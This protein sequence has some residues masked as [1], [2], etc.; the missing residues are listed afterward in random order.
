M[1]FVFNHVDDAV[2]G[3]CLPQFSR[4]LLLVFLAAAA[5][6]FTQCLLFA[7]RPCEHSKHAYPVSTGI[8]EQGV[9]IESL[10]MSRGFTTYESNVLFALR[11][12]IDH[13]VVGG[14]WVEL[15]AGMHT[16][17]GPASSNKL[18]HC[19]ME[20]HIHCNKL[21]SHKPEGMLECPIEKAVHVDATH[22]FFCRIH[23]VHC[24]HGMAVNIELRTLAGEWQR[25]APFRI[26]SVDI[27]CAGRKV[28]PTMA[29]A[30]C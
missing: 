15:P 22:V 9:Y 13:E 1:H 30:N 14:N 19:Q 6:H 5:M 18:S 10:N 21:I 23:L 3:C 4:L 27:E 8:L 29:A 2:H 17:Q 16:Y 20:A 7:F 11:F 12:M 28:T 25:L 24:R 26:L